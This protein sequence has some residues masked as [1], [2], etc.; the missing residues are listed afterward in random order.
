MSTR[1]MI[2]SSGIL[3][4]TIA[5][6]LG[7]AGCGGGAPQETTPDGSPV[8]QLAPGDTP[9]DKEKDIPVTP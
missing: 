9:L 8:L 4:V 6:S 2:G 1:R 5:L 7:L 3:L